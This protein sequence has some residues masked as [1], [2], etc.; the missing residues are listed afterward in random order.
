MLKNRTLKNK[1]IN[2]PRFQDLVF[3]IG[4]LTFSAILVLGLFPEKDTEE[5]AARIS[6][7]YM[8]MVGPV[9]LAIYF[10][11][12]SFR[13]KLFLKSSD[14]YSSITFKMGLAFVTVGVLPSILIILITSNFINAAISELITEKTAYALEESVNLTFESIEGRYNSMEGELNCLSHLLNKGLITA[15]S[16]GGRN[17]IASLLFVKGYNTG[18]Y[19]VNRNDP[20]SNDITPFP[21]ANFRKEYKEGITKFYRNIDLKTQHISNI[22]IGNNSI[23]LGSIHKGN[24]ITVIYR[25]IPARV[26]ERMDLF[27]ES[28]QNYKRPEFLKPY[29]KIETGIL[30]LFLA[31]SVVLLSISVSFFLSRN[32]TKPVLELAEA[33]GNIAAGDFRINLKRDAEDELAFLFNSFNKMAGELDKSRQIMYQTQKLE[34]WKEVAKKLVHEIK[35]PLTPIRLSAE[36]MQKRLK[37]NPAD[38]ENIVLAGTETIIEEVNVLMRISSEFSRFARLPEMK[39]EIQ[40]INP[41]IENCVNIYRGHEG[42]TFNVNLNNSIPDIFIDKTLIRQALNNLLKNAV[43]A[44]GGKGSITI[45]SELVHG[46]KR[47]IA[48]LRILDNGVGIREE[49]IDKV[50][51]PAFSRKEEG[52]GLGLAI[53]EKIVLEHLG[54][55]YCYSVYGEGTEFIIDLPVLKKEE[56]PSG[57]NTDS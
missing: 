38:I 4:I 37:E 31:M 5:G 12:I 57:E 48:R 13:R 36:R 19:K 55:I 49:D 56:I 35:N 54:K 26:Y 9:I 18:F 3:V 29:L 28:L 11:S 24:I 44:V 51:E 27:R 39:G 17:Y 41:I 15:D 25:E 21:E 16:G 34:A 8:L 23:L 43:D 33:A 53:V 45:I 10:I 50:F 47:D 1:F 2:K 14:I 52:T 40:N 20:L 7:I 6:F 42:I 30:L 32:I 22:S 46:E